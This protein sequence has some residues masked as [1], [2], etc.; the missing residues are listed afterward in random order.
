MLEGTGRHPDPQHPEF[1]RQRA[2]RNYDYDRCAQCH[3]VSHQRYRE[4]EH[5]KALEKERRAADDGSAAPSATGA[6]MAPTCGECHS[7]HYDRSGLSRLEVGRRQVEVCG[8]CHPRYAAS[9]MKN[10]HGRS[11]VDLGNDRSAYCTDCHGA[12]RT[13]SLEKSGEALPACLRC[14]PQAEP[15]FANVVI[16]EQTALAVEEEATPRDAATLWIQ[17]VRIAVIA[18]VILSLVFFFGHST[19]WLLRE[20]HEKLRKH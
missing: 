1:L 6:T 14:H 13:A 11:G 18:V 5:A 17:R 8:Q 19:L 4:G 2:S 9:Y 7:S 20:L 12:H 15:E 16:H 3:R 10:I